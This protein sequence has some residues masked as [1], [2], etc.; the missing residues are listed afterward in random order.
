MVPQTCRLEYQTKGR[1]GLSEVHD[2]TGQESRLEDDVLVSPNQASV[3]IGARSTYCTYLLYPRTFLFPPAFR[4]SVIIER[5]V[6][7]EENS[8]YTEGPGLM[9]VTTPLR[10]N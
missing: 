3:Q 9:M 7:H 2:G 4:L 10:Q 1:Y 5:T 6:T 8:I